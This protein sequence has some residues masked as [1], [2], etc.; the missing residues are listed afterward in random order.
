MSGVSDVMVVASRGSALRARRNVVK[1]SKVAATREAGSAG[2]A[3]AV[4][5]ADSTI[6][7]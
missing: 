4:R 1:S 2:T 3:A 5:I 7:T 6:A